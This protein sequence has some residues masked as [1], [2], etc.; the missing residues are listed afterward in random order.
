MRSRQTLPRQTLPRPQLAA[1]LVLLLAACL[2][3][4]RDSTSA[5]SDRQSSA[6]AA[7]TADV[8][9][10]VERTLVLEMAGQTLGVLETRLDK[11]ADGSWTIHERME[12]SLTRDGGGLDEARFET[13]TEAVYVYGPDRQLV[14]ERSVE[15][16]GGVVITR[17]I[18]RS[19]DA[20]ISRYE[21]P[22]RTDEARFEV[23]EDYRSDFSVD[24][25]LVEAWRSSGE[26]LTRSYA[27]FDA[28]RERFERREVSLLG[29]L[30]YRFGDAVVPAYRFR[31][32]EEDGTIIESI[33]DHDFM[34][35]E[36]TIGE[37]FVARVVNEAPVLGAGDGAR[38]TAEVPVRGRTSP[39]WR[40]LAEQ[41]LTVTIAGEDPEAPALWENNAYHQVERGDGSYRMTLRSTRP[42]A[43]FRAP[44]LPLRVADP[45]VQRYLGP[46]TMAQSDDPRIVALAERLVA[47]E[48]DALAVARRIVHHVYLELDKKSGVR[49]SATATEVLASGEGDCTEHAVLAVAL[50]RAAGIPAR[51]LDGIVLLVGPQGQV[52]A[53]FHAWAEIWLGEW[54]GIDATVDETG[55]T[56][57][58]LLFGIDEPGSISSSGKLMRAVG[59]VAI[60]VG[61]HRSFAAQ[62]GSGPE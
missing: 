4:C 51:T 30:E 32:R 34:P 28:E 29:E 62:A 40:R 23:P 16:E 48:R 38:I 61:E 55:T 8:A 45:Q 44:S 36:L 13:S 1:L 31:T 33:T 42:S 26:V 56:A 22:G 10:S 21:G 25:E 57:R 43:E 5:K 52:S 50:M 11:G 12:M 20:L 2:G 17:T 53:G 60:E 37:L 19:G 18:E 47:G 3:A 46:T 24:F 15:R 49:G 41:Q 35:L 39:D 6:R 9:E 58:Y 27:A 54:I 7:A 14:S 59:R